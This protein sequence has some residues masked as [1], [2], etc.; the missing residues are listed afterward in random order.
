MSN[1]FC[2]HNPYTHHLGT[3]GDT[4]PINCTVDLRYSVCFIIVL[5]NL[6]CLLHIWQSNVLFHKFCAYSLPAWHTPYTHLWTVVLLTPNVSAS[7]LYSA[8]VASYCYTF[9]CRNLGMMQQVLQEA[10]LYCTTQKK[11]ICSSR[12]SESTGPL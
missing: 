4:S 2:L 7:I 9:I 8:Q 6:L 1:L 5:C 3:D 10:L 11:L 12:N